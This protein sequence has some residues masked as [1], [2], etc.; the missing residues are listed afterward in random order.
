[1]SERKAVLIYIKG[2]PEPIY[3]SDAT[4]EVG[5]SDDTTLVTVTPNRAAHGDR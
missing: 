3:F 4:V 5:T 1:M 2:E